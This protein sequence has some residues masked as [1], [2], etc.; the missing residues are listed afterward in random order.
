MVMLRVRKFQRHGRR[1]DFKFV[2]EPKVEAVKIGLP[3]RHTLNVS[4]VPSVATQQLGSSGRENRCQVAQMKIAAKRAQQQR[5]QS[6]PVFT[7]DNSLLAGKA[8]V[9]KGSANV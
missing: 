8:I 7:T 4:I 5:R 1:V 2:S 9:S 6:E 3:E